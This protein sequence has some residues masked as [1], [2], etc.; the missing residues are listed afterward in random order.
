[1][2]FSSGGAESGAAAGSS[3]G[4]WGAVV[5]GIAG[6]LFG[7]SSQDA[8]N[9][10]N[11]ENIQFQEQ[12]Y[13]QQDPFS[14]QGNRQQY[15]PMLNELARGGPSSVSNDPMYQQLNAKSMEDMSR[16]LAASGQGGSGQAMLA[17]QQN[18]QGNMMNYW[19]QMM[20]QYS[21]LSG[22]S[23]GR[24]SPIQGQSPSAAFGQS[25]Q[26]QANYGGSFGMLMSGIQGIFG[27]PG[28]NPNNAQASLDQSNAQSGATTGNTLNY[29]AT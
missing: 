10:A 25:Q 18:S 16:G 22:A 4:P 27:S 9:Q 13:Q 5:G 7:G 20:G 1:M 8:A 23:G 12:M 21:S 14:A 2:A 15:V 26:T 28:N 6:G 29:G 19:Q 11:A 3:L 24:T 17:L